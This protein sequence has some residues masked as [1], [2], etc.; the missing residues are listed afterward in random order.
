MCPEMSA[1]NPKEFP[2]I[3][4]GCK[5]ILV[6]DDERLVADT[7]VLILNSHGFEARAGY[8]GQQ[9]L[10][11]VVANAPDLL[12]LDVVLPDIDGIVVAMQLNQRVPSV[13]ILLFSGQASTSDLLE[14]ARAQGQNF[15]VLAKPIYPPELLE[16]VR[17]L[18][19]YTEA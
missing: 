19:E 9:A 7:L 18:T 13:K 11:E 2:R 14:S 15:E 17:K 8:S 3:S 16:K 6:V 10:D 5:K 12:L 4:S 1:P